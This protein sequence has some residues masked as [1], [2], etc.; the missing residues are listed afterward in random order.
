MLPAA[1]E[2]MSLF[3]RGWKRNNWIPSIF[4]RVVRYSLLR[5]FG[6]SFLF[7]LKERVKFFLPNVRPLYAPWFSFLSSY[8]SFRFTAFIQSLR[9]GFPA[10]NTTQCKDSFLFFPFLS[11]L[12]FFIVYIQRFNDRRLKLHK[13]TSRRVNKFEGKKY[14]RKLGFSC[15]RISPDL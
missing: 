4:F 9:P 8:S 13:S 6:L 10:L 1:G 12:Y 14:K 3:F 2:G 11:W 15:V 5:F 7:I